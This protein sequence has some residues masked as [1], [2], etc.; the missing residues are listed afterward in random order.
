VPYL[1][2]TLKDAAHQFCE[3]LN[4][5]LNTTVTK[6]RLVEFGPKDYPNAQRHV[7]FWQNGAVAE[8]PLSTRFGV[9]RLYL[10]DGSLL[11]F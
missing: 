10:T 11:W 1:G 3:A 7:T 8:A 9:V 2:A 6:A 4:R 5:V